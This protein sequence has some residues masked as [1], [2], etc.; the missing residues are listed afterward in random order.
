[1]GTLWATKICSVCNGEPQNAYRRKARKK[2]VSH[3]G[4]RDKDVIQLYDP[5]S[6]S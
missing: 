3:I 5:L 4:S 2:T 1:M 6:S